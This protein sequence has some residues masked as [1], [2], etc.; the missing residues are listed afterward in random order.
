[1][2]NPA[3]GWSR[4]AI[5]I[6][7]LAGLAGCDGSTDVG[8]T[9][10]PPP[11]GSPPSPPP[12]PPPP[13]TN[14]QDRTQTIFTNEAYDPAH[15]MTDTDGKQLIRSR[16]VVYL[17]D[18]ALQDE[19]DDFL[20]RYGASITSSI[21]GSRSMAIKVPDPVTIDDLNALIAAM[22][23]EPFVDAVMKELLPS[24]KVLPDNITEGVH[25][26]YINIAHQLAVDGAAAWN[27]KNAITAE[28]KVLLYDFFGDGPTQLE[29]YL[30]ANLSGF[31]AVGATS[32]S[33]HGYHVA[34]IIA[35][36]FGGGDLEPELVTGVV[37]NRINLFTM[38]LKGA[39]SNSDNE[40]MLLDE[41]AAFAGTSVLSTSLGWN[42]ACPRDSGLIT[43]NSSARANKWGL[44]WA[45][46]VR[47]AGVES[48]MLHATAASN[49][50]QWCSNPAEGYELRDAE[51]A[52]DY[53]AAALK[54]DLTEADGTV[55]P[56]LENTLVVEN[57]MR[58][59]FTDYTQ[60]PAR[61]LCLHENSFVGGD[62]GGIG[63]RVTSLGVTGAKTLSGTSMATPQVAGLAA[64]L[65][66]I[67]P[68]LTPLQIKE[69]LTDTSDYPDLAGSSECSDF[70][71][72]APAINAYS[73]V[74]ALDDASALNGDPNDAPVRL[75]IL[76]VADGFA[77]GGSDGIFD[78]RDLEYYI[79]KLNE[80]EDEASSGNAVV[81]YSR[82]DLN[83]DGFDGGNSRTKRFNLDIDYP[84]NYTTVTQQIEEELVEFDESALT[85]NEILC[86]YAYSDLYTGNTDER[87]T[88]MAPRCQRGTMAV[89]VN[90]FRT[91]GTGRGDDVYCDDN[92]AELDEQRE[93]ISLLPVVSGN[94]PYEQRP[95][96]HYWHPGDFDSEINVR[97][98]AGELA[99]LAN[100]DPFNPE[101][102]TQAFSTETEFNS[103]LQ[104]DG[105]GNR[106]NIDV[107]FR[108]E[109][110]C[111][112]HPIYGSLGCSFAN[113]NASWVADFDYTL[114][115]A[116]NLTLVMQLNCAAE[117]NRVPPDP[118][119]P[120]PESIGEQILSYSV[121]RYD[122]TGQRVGIGTY[123]AEFFTCDESGVV[124]I[125]QDINLDAPAV[126]GTTDNL[127]IRVTG[128]KLAVTPYIVGI[129]EQEGPVTVDSHLSG[130]VEVR[131]GN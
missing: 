28:P 65:L 118:S 44:I 7:A 49:R 18:D 103:T 42:C 35:G 68:E 123:P 121:R 17:S 61:V 129:A 85:D 4:T 107:N 78:E 79:T 15:V 105:N 48:K 67:D 43:C 110:E 53:N 73:A 128:S 10:S 34:G 50:E 111:K 36:D 71:T 64:Y 54:L 116:L 27:A 24:T 81:K 87:R 37:P 97:T 58:N 124:D 131:P 1:M 11:P 113:A 26:D 84:P 39:L 74:L 38:D 57:L 98:V 51:T 93:T 102:G 127:I 8:N 52:S 32:P 119:K 20:V 22:E 114:R 23:S 33:D 9:A 100:G 69:I 2:W 86:Y 96:G 83:G 92:P 108:A 41:A 5:L 66:A 76:D 115:T 130:F 75:A 95:A 122:H 82:I 94:D 126:A 90:Y 14:F 16:L 91:Q 117:S 45:N 89:Y 63:D 125:M 13:P 40:T 112:I 55:I 109:S 72:P 12:P 62:I 106:L 31:I 47:A 46:K 70:L 99:Y 6:V 77:S 88:L 30:D 3:T 80:A 104:H 120:N 19:V 101:C 25:E 21:A 60:T 56:P 29:T 59:T